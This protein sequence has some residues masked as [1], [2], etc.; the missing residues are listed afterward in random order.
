MHTTIAR[1]DPNPK[2]T[3]GPRLVV[4]PADA[5]SSEEARYLHHEAASD[6]L[7]AGKTL[8]AIVRSGPLST[9]DQ[10][11]VTSANQEGKTFRICLEVRTYTGA[12]LANVVTIGLAQV[13]LGSLP[14]GSY[15]IEVSETHMEFSEMEQPEQATPGDSEQY[16]LQFTTA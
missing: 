9:P 8:V 1:V 15:T 7:P 6:P 10:I 2:L 4:V 11:Q 5:G 14:P 16:Q 13:E 3:N 12:L